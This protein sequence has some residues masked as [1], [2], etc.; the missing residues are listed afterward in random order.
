MEAV[1]KTLTEMRL[2]SQR[3]GLRIYRSYSD[4]VGGKILGLLISLRGMASLL[5][6]TAAVSVG[7]FKT[8]RPV[9]HPL[10]RQQMVRAGY[11]LL[12]MVGFLA[13]ALGMVVIGQTTMLLSRFGV[14]S[15]I[16][17]VMVSVVVRELGPILAALLVLARVGTANVVELGTARAC[18]EVEALEALGID[19]IHYLV[20]P[21]VVG[22]AL[23]IYALTV[24][25]ILFAL[26]S[27]FL[28]AFLVGVPVLPGEYFQQLARSLIWQDFVLLALKTFAFG[29]FIAIVTCYEGLAQPLRL[30]EVSRATASAV[31]QC[32]VGVVVL[33]ALFIFVYLVV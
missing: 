9:V 7:K 32:V 26:L 25:F 30:E 33:D 12:P 19:P 2:A 13:F 23:A 17:T 10:I 5:L 28:F 11:R 20:V 16:G 15:Y 4:F 1:S 8:A 21:R 31:A 14:Q 6:I 18:G 24:Y 29:V 27:G 22:L 3:R